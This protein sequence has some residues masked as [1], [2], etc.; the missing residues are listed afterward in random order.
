MQK[1]LK[2][3]LIVVWVSVV[4]TFHIAAPQSPILPEN[5]IILCLLPL[6]HAS[7]EE[8]SAVL[9]PFLSSSGTISP[10]TP[11]NTLI[12]KDKTSIVR[13]LIK[14]VKGSEDLGACQNF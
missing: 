14:A 3:G 2:T 12:I 9:A 10:Y 7:A 11:T 5:Q 13:M 4:S 8:L 1:Y 6:Y